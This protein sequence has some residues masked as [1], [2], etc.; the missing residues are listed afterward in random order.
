MERGRIIRKVGGSAA[1]FLLLSVVGSSVV[2]AQSAG[3]TGTIKACV[4]TQNGYAMRLS[5][6][7]GCKS[8][9][10]SIEWNAQG[11]EGQR[12]ARGAQGEQGIQGIQGIQGEKGDTGATGETGE[13]GPVG[14][15]G[16]T[17][18][19]GP[20]GE[21]GPQGPI[22]P[23]GPQ[24]P[25]GAPGQDAS[26]STSG[27]H[28]HEV[29]IGSNGNIEGLRTTSDHSSRECGPNDTVMTMVFGNH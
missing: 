28:T 1:L 12:G 27:F 6:P 18:P 8:N 17:G 5:P 9:E 14:E 29:C 15:T 26:F 16:A 25:T 24:G 4:N 7:E 22:G 19:R 2:V 23:Q 20:A 21:T 10:R 11:I 3:P 13:T